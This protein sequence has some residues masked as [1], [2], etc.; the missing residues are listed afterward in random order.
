MYTYKYISICVYIYCIHIYMHT[1]STTKH[2]S[3]V[4]KSPANMGLIHSAA[5]C[6][7]MLQCITACCSM[8]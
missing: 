5:M 2:K 6:C 4:Q 1:G 3:C 7:N 8:V